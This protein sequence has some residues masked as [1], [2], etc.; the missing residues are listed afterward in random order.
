MSK[1]GLINYSDPNCDKCEVCAKSK[2]IKK[3]VKILKKSI[4][5]TPKSDCVHDDALRDYITIAHCY[6][7]LN[8][9]KKACSYLEKVED[10]RKGRRGS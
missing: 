2:I 9:Y 10:Q 5:V 8:Q 4:L 1:F 7:K 3:H 6:A